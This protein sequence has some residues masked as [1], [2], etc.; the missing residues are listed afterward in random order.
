[1]AVSNT[2]IVEMRQRTGLGIMVCRDALIRA[3]D[4]VEEALDLLRRD[5]GNVSFVTTQDAGA[6]FTYNHMNRIGVVLSLRCGTDFTARSEVFLSLGQELALHVAGIGPKDVGELLEQEYVRDASRKVKDL[7][8][9]VAAA[10]KESVRVASF[11]RL[12]V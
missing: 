4:D 6:V 2:K 1:M 11:V 8:A 7:I 5:R 3:N 10:T 9:E 12:E